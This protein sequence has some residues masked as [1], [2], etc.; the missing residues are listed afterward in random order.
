MK[1]SL[2]Q[3]AFRPFFLFGSAFAIVTILMW[4]AYL[5]GHLAQVGSLAPML[6]HPHEMVY[7]FT[8]AIIAGFVLTAAQNWTGKRGVHGT[9][10]VALVTVWLLARLLL[11]FPHSPALLSAIVDLSF[12]PFLSLLLVPYL[13]TSDIKSERIFFVFFAL[14]FIGNALVHLEELGWFTGY[15]RKGL[16]LGLNTILLIIIFIGGRVI[17]FFTESSIANAQPR[18]RK[19]IEIGSSVSAAAYLVTDFFIAGTLV[20]SLL[21]FLTAGVHFFRLAGWQVPRVRRV[22][23]IWVL[24]L[25]YLWLV[26]G[27]VLAGLAGLGKFNPSLATHAF[28]MGGLG[29]IIYGMISRVSLGHTGRRLH[30]AAWTVA[31]YVSLNIA[32]WVRTLGPVLLPAF[33]LETVVTSGLFWM[34]AFGIFIAVY[35]TILL[36]QRTDGRPG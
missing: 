3:L 13:F 22:P 6:W 17:P 19:W 2:W 28:T 26:I 7:G 5:T 16:F 18:T 36:S 9:P 11:A 1:T 10:L 32:A 12:Y 35:A 33:Y 15:A 23:L 34:L 25:G 27:F 30:P 24:H 4:V 31:G 29:V 14:L 21:A 20:H 8:T